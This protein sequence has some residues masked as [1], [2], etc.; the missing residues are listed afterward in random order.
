MQKNI[1]KIVLL[2]FLNL[3]LLSNCYKKKIDF[4]VP[5][6]DLQKIDFYTLKITTNISEA[7]NYSVN[8]DNL[9]RI[10][11]GTKVTISNTIGYYKIIGFYSASNDLLSTSSTYSFIM[12]SNFEIKIVFKY[13]LLYYLDSYNQNNTFELVESDPLVKSTRYHKGYE[14]RFRSNLYPYQPIMRNNIPRIDIITS[15]DTENIFA[16]KPT[17]KE[18]TEYLPM[19]F[20][21]SNCEEKYILNGITGQIKARGN[22]SLTFDKKPFNLKL[23]EK[24]NILGINNGNKFKRWVLNA[25]ARDSSNLR[26]LTAF[27]LGKQVFGYDKLFSSDFIFVELYLN[28]EY[29]G[30]YLVQEYNQVNKNRVNIDDVEKR[31][32]VNAYK[33][34]DIGYYFEYDGYAVVNDDEE[35]TFRISYNNNASLKTLDGVIKYPPTTTMGGIPRTTI[36]GY[37]MKSKIYS[38]DQLNFI[39]NYVDKVYEIIYNAVYKKKYYVFDE[40]YSQ[41]IEIKNTTTYETVDKVVNIR[42]FVDMYILQEIFRDPDVAWG[43]KYFQVDFSTKGDKKLAWSSIWDNDLAFGTTGNTTEGY[44]AAGRGTTGAINPWHCILVHEKWFMHLVKQKWE[45]LIRNKVLYNSLHY[46]DEYRI[47]YYNKFVEDF[48]KWGYIP[49]T[50]IN[51]SADYKQAAKS[52]DG[53]VNFLFEWLVKR[54]NS[55]NSL[56]GDGSILFTY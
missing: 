49:Q 32:P 25:V 28:N 22:G 13:D 37:T 40:N 18:E 34:I 30:L 14:K 9:E 1:L 4:G 36:N 7:K 56:Y 11:S 19:T 41:L 17:K 42:S 31:E 23:N 38:D 29:W 45:D 55:L 5:D 26:D 27:Y 21:L 50:A 47:N 48:N 54:Y 10:E 33:G 12:D 20:S 51:T 24:T 3:F 35:H 6:S 39:S 44:F 15:T 16:T 46:I 43:S 53:G 52:V 8:V 2:F